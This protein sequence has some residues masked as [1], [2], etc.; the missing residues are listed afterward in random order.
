MKFETGTVGLLLIAGL[1]TVTP[2]GLYGGSITASLGNQAITGLNNRSFRG[3]AAGGG[4]ESRNRI[5]DCRS[6]A[7]GG[8]L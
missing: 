2:Y 6:C 8:G 7:Q 3:A 4:Q 5:P 1:L